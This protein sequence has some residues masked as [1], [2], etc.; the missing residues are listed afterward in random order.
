[1][2]LLRKA[3]TR[4]CQSSR[5]TRP[6][7]KSYR[8]DKSIREREQ[9]PVLRHSRCIGYRRLLQEQNTCCKCR[10]LDLPLRPPGRARTCRRTALLFA[11]GTDTCFR[12]LPYGCTQ[13]RRNNSFVRRC[14]HHLWQCTSPPAQRTYLWPRH[15]PPNS[16]RRR[17]GT[18]SRGLGTAWPCPW[19]W[20]SRR[21][22]RPCSRPRPRQHQTSLAV[23]IDG[24]RLTPAF[25]SSHQ[26]DDRP[27]TVPPPATQA[28]PAQPFALRVYCRK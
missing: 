27:C 17:R 11:M 23:R 22:P 1:M 7:D 15:T 9:E 10:C 14:I 25:G 18:S 5:C 20:P 26:S 28:R 2:N 13:T 8:T 16:S 21:S 4:R 12:A 24:W 6:L 3:R 19:S